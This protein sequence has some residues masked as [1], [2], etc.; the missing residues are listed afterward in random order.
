MGFFNRLFNGMDDR[1]KVLL[2]KLE[3]PGPALRR[4]AVQYKNNAIDCAR[5]E[6]HLRAQVQK[7]QDGELKQKMAD[8]ADKFQKRASDLKQ[9]SIDCESKAT[10]LAVK[11]ESLQLYIKETRKATGLLDT[12]HD[13]IFQEYED[14]IKDLEI[15][16][17]VLTDMEV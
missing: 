5:Q 17:K 8:L 14:V 3:K 11:Y 4:S 15:E 1:S 12:S 16:V 9:K 2:R 10:Y 7:L 13:N 6:A